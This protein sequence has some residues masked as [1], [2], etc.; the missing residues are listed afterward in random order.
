MLEHML[1]MAQLFSDYSMLLTPHQ[2]ELLSLYYEE[3]Y[4]LAEIAQTHQVSR[5]AVR[6]T[7]KRGEKILEQYESQL[8]LYEKRIKR[9]ALL[10]KLKE[11]IGEDTQLQELIEMI[12]KLDE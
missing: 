1:R 11:R 5:Q 6:D 2:Q 4:S 3:D 9:E 8:H 7:I 12:I 10:I